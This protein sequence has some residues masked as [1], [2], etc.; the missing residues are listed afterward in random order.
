MQYVFLRWLPLLL[1]WTSLLLLKVLIIQLLT[2]G[3]LGGWLEPGQRDVHG[4]C[5]KINLFNWTTTSFQQT[6]HVPTSF[7]SLWQTVSQCVFK[8]WTDNSRFVVMAG[9]DKGNYPFSVSPNV[10]TGRLPSQLHQLTL[11]GSAFITRC[12]HLFRLHRWPSM[13]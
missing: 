8:V 7:L 13:Y 12:I 3:A 1:R 9:D 4:P 11:C 5:R 2:P 10:W 6:L